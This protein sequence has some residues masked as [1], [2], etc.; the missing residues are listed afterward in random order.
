ML[1]G[2]FDGNDT[3]DAIMIFAGMDIGSRTIKVALFD[4]IGYSIIACKLKD[5]GLD[6]QN[7]TRSIYDQI[8]SEA[9]LESSNVTR[10]VATGYG[11]NAIE[12]ADAMVTEITC[13]AAGVRYLHPDA[14]TIIDIGGED[15][16]VIRLDDHG[17]VQD[18]AMNDRCAAGTGRFL[19]I[20]AHRLEGDLVSVAR[21]AEGCSNPAAIN[22]MCVVF[23]ETEIVGLLASGKPVQEI[24]AGVQKSVASRIVGMVGRQARDP[25]YFTG[26]VALVPGMAQA[27]S[28][29]LG[30]EVKV[31]LKA[32][33][34]GAL[35]AALMASRQTA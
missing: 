21:A 25:F 35:G 30:H 32:Q 19:E 26:G 28:N 5:Q 17:K 1:A 20:V 34:T 11:R 27:L 8:L 31:S 2:S 24:M 10:S 18:F 22:S 23:A 16:K 13:H 9:G 4:T 33:F 3:G 15:S 6:Q 14:R 12:F 29:A 7:L